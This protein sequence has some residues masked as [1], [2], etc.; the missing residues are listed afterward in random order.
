MPAYDVETLLFLEEGKKCL[1]SVIDVMGLVTEPIYIIPLNSEEVDQMKN[2]K[3]A[4]VYCAPRTKY[5]KYVL[6]DELKK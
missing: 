5:T 6:I 1:G 2:M 3:G 4:K